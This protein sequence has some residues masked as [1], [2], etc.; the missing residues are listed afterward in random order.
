MARAW[1]VTQTD[2]II[3]PS[4]SRGSTVV[5]GSGCWRRPDERFVGAFICPAENKGD[6]HP[7]VCHSW[8]MLNL[9][10]RIIGT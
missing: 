1:A 3:G 2:L 10:A 7:P 9:G 5:S 8:P 6:S 4:D